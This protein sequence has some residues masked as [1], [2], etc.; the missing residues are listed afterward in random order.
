MIRFLFETCGFTINPSVILF[1]CRLKRKHSPAK[2]VIHVTEIRQIEIYLHDY[3]WEQSCQSH[4]RTIVLVS[5]GNNR[6]S[7]TWE[8]SCQSQF[9][10]SNF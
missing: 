1:K 6:T 2:C 5:L 8:Q 3:A 10:L 9:S 7:V 4:L